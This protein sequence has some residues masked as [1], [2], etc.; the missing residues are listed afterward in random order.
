MKKYILMTCILLASMTAIGCVVC[1]EI[2]PSFPGPTYSPTVASPSPTA[3]P[4]GNPS[5]MPQYTEVD[6]GS[7]PY[8][9]MP[10]EVRVSHPCYYRTSDWTLPVPQEGG[11]EPAHHGVIHELDFWNP[12][13]ENK[14]ISVYNIKSAFYE[15]LDNP[16]RFIQSSEIFYDDNK[17]FFSQFVIQPNQQMTVLMYAYMS[18]GEYAKYA[19]HIVEP[20]SISVV[21]DV[22][23]T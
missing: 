3:A 15:T 16:G 22:P 21:P 6:T 8:M 14:T 18:D 23:Y 13:S 10:N 20:V 7:P 2:L 4:T 19:G 11:L 12:T 17:G 9:Y 1:K 5:A